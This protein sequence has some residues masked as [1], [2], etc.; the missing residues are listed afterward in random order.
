[1][2]RYNTAIMH[3]LVV[4]VVAP[5][6]GGEPKKNRRAYFSKS[7]NGQTQYD[8]RTSFHNPNE[9]RHFLEDYWRYHINNISA[10]NIDIIEKKVGRTYHVNCYSESFSTSFSRPDRNIYVLLVDENSVTTVLYYI[11][12]I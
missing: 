10:V 6:I 3:S 12:S 9:S 7:S 1:M 5:S 8:E 2:H 4:P 11:N